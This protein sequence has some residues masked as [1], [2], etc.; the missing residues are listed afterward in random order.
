M[1][2]VIEGRGRPKRRTTP[3]PNYDVAART[4]LQERYNTERWY[5]MVS[6]PVRRLRPFWLYDAIID[7]RE[8]VICHGYNGTLLPWDDPWWQF[9]KPPNHWGCRS[10]IRCVSR[11][12]ARRRGV[13]VNVP[14]MLPQ[15]GFGMSPRFAN[16]DIYLDL[17]KYDP[18]LAK[19]A[20]EKV[21]RKL[22]QPPRKKRP[23]NIGAV[24][25]IGAGAEF[26]REPVMTELNRAGLSRFYTGK[27]ALGRLIMTDDWQRSGMNSSNSVVST[28]GIFYYSRAGSLTIKVNTNRAYMAK[29]ARSL[30]MSGKIPTVFNTATSPEQA[31]AMAAVHEFGHGIHRHDFESEESKRV[32]SLISKRFADSNR[33]SISEYANINH[34]EYFAESFTAYQ[35]ERAWM[36]RN[37][38][39]AYRMVRDVL[40]I[41]GLL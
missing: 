24:Q 13:T 27:R 23:L 29:A 39:K 5:Q 18:Q 26:A 37:T 31:S 12:T 32:D 2:S 21:R 28:A 14:T 19:L 8:T 38:P 9:R 10:V 41:R 11:S 25:V 33:E 16:D 22:K 36:K 20:R 30:K 3:F 17:R 34:K 40:K 6:E 4:F 7:G 15:A 35:F 1:V